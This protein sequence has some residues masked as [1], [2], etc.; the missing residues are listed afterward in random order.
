MQMWQQ[1]L[2][3]QQAQQQ[4]YM[5]QMAWQ[6]WMAQQWAQQQAAQNAAQCAAQNSSAAAFQRPAQPVSQ[7]AQE[8]IV[9]P[10]GDSNPYARPSR[11]I[12][13]EVDQPF[14]PPEMEAEDEDAWPLLQW[15][16]EMQDAE[17]FDEYGED[18]DRTDASMPPKSAYVGRDEA[19]RAKERFWD[20]YLGGGV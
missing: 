16:E 4:Q 1:Y 2:Q 6:Q 18:E 15:P 19:A 7:P 10:S 5:Q 13:F 12:S 8:E 11:Q 17:L 20:K 9:R 3:Y 14:Y